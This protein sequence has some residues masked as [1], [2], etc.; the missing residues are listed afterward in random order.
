MVMQ[1]R[2]I[3]EQRINERLP[4]PA[5]G[6]VFQRL[7]IEHMPDNRKMGI[8]IRANVDVAADDF[9]RTDL[10]VL[11]ILSFIRRWP[12]ATRSRNGHLLSVYAVSR[13]SG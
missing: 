2:Q 9:H 3:L 11:L 6:P 10:I 1:P 8:N 4:Q 5:G 7:E 13:R 12:S